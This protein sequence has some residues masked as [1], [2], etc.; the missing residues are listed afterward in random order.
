MR[1]RV[2]PRVYKVSLKATSKGRE[3]LRRYT[4][5]AVLFAT[6]MLIWSAPAQPQM[7]IDQFR[8]DVPR[9]FT[10]TGDETWVGSARMLTI[11]YTDT[12]H[13][14]LDS[15]GTSL[16]IRRVLVNSDDT[17]QVSYGHGVITP[18]PGDTSFT[19]R[20][21]EKTYPEA[22]GHMS[23]DGTQWVTAFDGEWNQ[24]FINIREVHH[25]AF[26]AAVAR[27]VGAFP[28]IELM[29]ATYRRLR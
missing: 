19:I 22:T 6:A 24:W 29:D 8:Y 10:G 21:I 25:D 27:K 26:E 3:S 13:V 7:L 23:W 11:N 9:Y 14:S 12:V 5:L 1:L 16:L 2:R 4:A 28:A 15:T 18:E 17:V 20:W